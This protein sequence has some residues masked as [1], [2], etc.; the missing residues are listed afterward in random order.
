MYEKESFLHDH[1]FPY[2]FQK[3]ESHF[4]MQIMEI[5]ILRNKYSHVIMENCHVTDICRHF[6]LRYLLYMRNNV[7][8]HGVLS[9][10]IVF[11]SFQVEKPFNCWP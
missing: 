7:Y 1:T 8:S 2:I 11:S 10:Y 6:L 9:V 4:L 3:M 5:P